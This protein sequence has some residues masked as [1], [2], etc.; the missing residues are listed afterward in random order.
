MAERHIRAVIE[1]TSSADLKGEGLMYLGIIHL[2]RGDLASA[3]SALTEACSLLPG[4]GPAIYHLGRCEFEEKDYIAA[5]EL[6]QRA[7]EMG[8]PPW[9]QDDLRLYLGICHVRLEEFSE[10]LDVLGSV[11][12]V[13]APLFFYRGVALSGLE[14]P[15]EALECLKGALALGPDQEDLAAIHFY[16]GQCLKEM[17]QFLEAVSSLGMALQ[18]DPRGYEAWNLLGY[19]LFRL[20]RHREAIGAFVKALEINPN[21]AL[22]NANIGSNLR[23]LGDLEG[24]CRWYRRALRLDP[25]LVWA[26]ENLR[27]I[28]EGL[29]HRA[30]GI[31]PDTA[32]E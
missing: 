25:T 24:A 32:P 28:E 17:G 20:K 5:S 12:R 1:S 19:C 11:E 13:T 31:T 4:S 3:R 2:Q 14:R 10:A 16:A 30:K 15:K 18:A 27:K 6:F 21:S 7:L 22:D 26:R 8:V 29:Q 9:L 23:D